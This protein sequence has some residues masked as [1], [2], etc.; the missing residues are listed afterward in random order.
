MCP[1]GF[2]LSVLAKTLNP[3]K[4]AQTASATFDDGF[5]LPAPRIDAMPIHIALAYPLQDRAT[6]ERRPFVADNT[7]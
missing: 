5:L 1:H 6:G 3:S 2:W 7:V 4:K